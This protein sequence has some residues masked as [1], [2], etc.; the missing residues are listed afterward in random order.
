MSDFGCSISDVLIF[1]FI[2]IKNQFG[3]N[4][5]NIL[6][7]VTTLDNFLP[8]RTQRFHKGHKEKKNKN[9]VN[10]VKP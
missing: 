8:Q 5:N 4:T 3:R 2:E 7:S 10:F 1:K 9:I 6:S